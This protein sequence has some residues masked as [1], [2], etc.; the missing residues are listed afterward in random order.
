MV[1][2]GEG[3][4]IGKERRGGKQEVAV[5]EIEKVSAKVTRLKYSSLFNSTCLKERILLTYTKA[6]ALGYE[7]NVALPVFH[8]LTGCDTVSSLKSIEEKTA[9]MEWRRLLRTEI[10]GSTG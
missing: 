5:R 3:R 4:W 8:A 2:C 1:L 9:T 7:K 10:H 6:T